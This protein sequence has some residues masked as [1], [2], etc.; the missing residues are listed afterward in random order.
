MAAYLEAFT[1]A[2]QTNPGSTTSL[3]SNDDTV[4]SER[5][6]TRPEETAMGE[7]A[8]LQVASDDSTLC[9][10]V[11]VVILTESY[12]PPGPGSV[13]TPFRPAMDLPQHPA[14]LQHAATFHI[15]SKETAVRKLS[16]ETAVTVKNTFIDDFGDQPAPES[17]LEWSSCPGIVMTGEFHTKYPLMEE[18]HLRGDCR[19]CAYFLTKDDGCRAGGDCNFC[20]L[21]PVGAIKKKKKEKVRALK[22]R[23][24]LASIDAS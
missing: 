15:T 10:D 8:F 7:F 13:P 16:E 24:R 22:L 6:Y 17:V 18:S 5:E 19:P 9:H 21:C 4:C 3:R 12:F 20:H 23:D 1:K 2:I 14:P 11:P